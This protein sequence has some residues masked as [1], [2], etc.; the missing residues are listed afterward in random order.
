MCAVKTPARA[1]ILGLAVV[2]C[3]WFAVGIRQAHDIDQATSIITGAKL[4]TP[5]QAE[6]AQSLLTSAGWLYPGTEVDILKGR[7][8]IEKGQ[9]PLA[10]RIERS[11]TRTEPMN[12]NGWVWLANS[13]TSP[14]F[15]LPAVAHVLALD[16]KASSK[17]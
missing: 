7:L 16:P 17:S 5:A 9:R 4:P 14:K 1:A 12:L 15:S 6:H 8:A 10:Q 3:A 2:V 11:V 13:Y